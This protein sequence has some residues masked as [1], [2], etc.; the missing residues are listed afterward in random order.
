MSE[1]RIYNVNLIV[2]WGG[3]ASV[4]E[5]I[6]VPF[7]CRKVIIKPAIYNFKDAG[8]APNPYVHARITCSMLSDNNGNATIGIILPQVYS[9]GGM[10]IAGFTYMFDSPTVVNSNYIFNA[11]ALDGSALGTA[12]ANDSLICMEF[13]EA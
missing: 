7:P 3:N 2:A 13:Y 6:S 8:G 4:N 5:F 10:P 1:K 11:I 12:P 9:T